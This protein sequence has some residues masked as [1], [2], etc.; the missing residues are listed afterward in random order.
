MTDW[1][2]ELLKAAEGL[3]RELDGVADEMTFHQIDLHKSAAWLLECARKVCNPFGSPCT[4]TVGQLHD[5][6]CRDWS[7]GR[8]EA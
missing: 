4:C 3:E 5:T 1:R 8:K 2:A 7:P 6:E